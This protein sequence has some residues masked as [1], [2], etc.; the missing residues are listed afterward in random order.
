MEILHADSTNFEEVVLRSEKTV[1]LDFYAQWCG[2][3]KMLGKELEEMNPGEGYSI[4]KVDID[5]NPDLARQWKVQSVPTLFVIKNGASVVS[6]TGFL[7]KEE[8][9]KRIKKA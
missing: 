8:L 4:V 7:P 1:L 2:P 9:E 5:Q 6:I 3:C